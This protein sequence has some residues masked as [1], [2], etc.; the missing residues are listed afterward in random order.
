VGPGDF[1]FTTAS[2]VIRHCDVPNDFAAVLSGHIHRHQVLMSDLECRPLRV[3][4]LYPGSIERTSFAES[5][6]PKGFMVLRLGTRLDWEFR[7]LPARPMIRQEVAA[8]GLD[9]RSLESALHAI[10]AAAPRDAVL[11]IRITGEMTVSQW[12]LLSAPR[13]RTI[14]PDTMNVE[15]RPADGFNPSPD[16]A[17][18]TGAASAL[19][20]SLY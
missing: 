18:H 14:V 1:T 20:L 8:A 11:A 10:I 5:D 16:L 4:V 3:P 6:E 12:R 9:E 19:Q 2:D 13:M 7:K 15:I 17:P